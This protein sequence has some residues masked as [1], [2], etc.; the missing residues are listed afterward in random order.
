MLGFLIFTS[1]IGY[2]TAKDNENNPIEKTVLEFMEKCMNNFEVEAVEKCF[3]PDFIG[4]SMENDSINT[5]TRSTF[6]DFVKRMKNKNNEGERETRKAKILSSKTVKEIGFV[7][8]ETYRGDKLMGTDYIVLLKTNGI[9]KFARS[10]TLYH[11]QEEKIDPE[12]E[13]EKIKKVIRES[14]VDAA[15]NY[16]DL[17]KWKKGFHPEFTGLTRVGVELEKD[18]FSDWE[19]AIKTM[20]IKEPEGH[21]QL[22]TGRIPQI[23]IRGHMGMAEV[24]IYYGTTLN[25][26]AYILLFRFS[27]GWKVVSKVGLNHRQNEN[28]EI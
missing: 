10:I 15:G 2:S 12:S 22:I 11:S 19:E 3:H 18:T 23:D 9:W 28:N 7:E 27:D 16:W 13:K 8:F 26:T 24:K 1:Q 21:G 5:A 25:E 14:L 6:I 20:E 4:L 17:E